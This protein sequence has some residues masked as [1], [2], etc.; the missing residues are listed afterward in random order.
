[1]STE[2]DEL[3]LDSVG[4]SA[5]GG[6]EIKTHAGGPET[7]A[8]LLLMAEAMMVTLAD[9]NAENYVEMELRA[10]DKKQYV[11]T[12]QRKGHITPHQ[13]RVK[14]EEALEAAKPRMVTTL[15]ELEELPVGSVVLGKWLAQ[16]WADP[17]GEMWHVAGKG[18]YWDLEQFTGRGGLPAIVLQEG[19]A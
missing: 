13:A 3:M 16:K 12:L 17:E 19:T 2:R 9:N 1:M 10:S 18:M 15:D 6:I 8:A 4:P 7:S 5:K 11:M 14:A